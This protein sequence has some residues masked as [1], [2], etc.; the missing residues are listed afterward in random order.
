MKV[1]VCDDEILAGQQV[2]DLLEKIL[3]YGSYCLYTDEDRILTEFDE[4]RDI[5]VVIMDIEWYGQ[6]R[7]IE[8]ARKIISFCPD[9][10]VIFLTGYTE[11]Y[12]QNIFF[13]PTN[14]SGFLIKPVDEEI[15]RINLKKIQNSLEERFK[16]RF[17]ISGKWETVAIKYDDILYLESSAHKIFVITKRGIYCCYDKLEKLTVQFPES[18]VYCH[19]S[20]LVNM[21][22]TYGIRQDRHTFQMTDGKEIPISKAHYTYTKKR[23]FE[24]TKKKAFLKIDKSSEGTEDERRKK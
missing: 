14:L 17:V 4:N 6:E 11:K 23:F 22:E 20:Y 7:G 12:V 2:C 5:D 19:K 21:D 10:S 9:I 1:V 16:E 3:G 13:R 8:L 24:Y 18:F 15:L